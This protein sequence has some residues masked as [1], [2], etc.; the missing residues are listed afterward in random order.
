MSD[1]LFHEIIDPYESSFAK[2]REDGKKA[3]LQQGYNDG[4]QLGKLKALEVG[5][6]LGYMSSICKMAL[7]EIENRYSIRT[8]TSINN[9]SN[10]LCTSTS[11]S[12]STSTN[13][14]QGTS[15]G[16]DIRAAT[17]TGSNSNSNSR[18]SGTGSSSS[19]ERKRKRLVDL[20]D[21]IEAFPTPETIFK[22]R[23]NV[24]KV[25]KEEDPS[26][27]VQEGNGD[28][29]G[30]GDTFGNEK[31]A[32]Q[33]DQEQCDTATTTTATTTTSSA[34]HSVDVDIVSMM[35]RLRA[36]FKTVLIQTNRSDLSLKNIM[37]RSKV[38]SNVMSAVQSDGK[39]ER[40]TK[41]QAMIELGPI[42]EW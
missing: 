29:D 20:L 14:I 9:A 2:G 25:E 33:T 26:N 7:E 28:G 18:S 1:D 12:T 4:F 41:D 5:I 8:G 36:K 16:A 37:D 13:M 34:K 21:A 22:Q 3:A 24:A 23:K 6:E 30:D 10:G 15:V 32:I 31:E 40:T 17:G 11:T 35:Q 39:P 42:D 19:F 27:K 38:Q